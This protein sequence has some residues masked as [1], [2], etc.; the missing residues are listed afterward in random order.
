[1]KQ[2]RLSVIKFA[3][4]AGVLVA[5][6]LLP[7]CASA[8]S[9]DDDVKALTE[10]AEK[11]LAHKDLQTTINLA[12]QSLKL[13]PTP[14]AYMLR[15][16]ASMELF[17]F[18]DA[19]KDA[20][21][22]IEL[23]PKLQPAFIVR[24]LARKSLGDT[25]GSLADAK[26][27]AELDPTNIFWL[28]VTAM[29]ECEG[30]DYKDAL[31]HY[32]QAIALLPGKTKPGVGNGGAG[33]GGAGATG[34]SSG[35]APAAI[36]FG[37]DPRKVNLDTSLFAGRAEANAMLGN[38]KDSLSDYDQ[39]IALNPSSPRYFVNRGT[40]KDELGDHKGAISDYDEAIKLKP[41]D[42]VA[43]KLRSDSKNDLGDKA[44]AVA[45]LEKS[46]SLMK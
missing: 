32:S 18:A 41:D 7:I 33:G 16:K 37:A 17:K 11:A 46:S 42:P 1:M 24:A 15:A 35:G 43:Y 14:V 3:K 44:G 39:A 23:E 26:K 22:A 40:V 9:T 2:M 29:M 6:F 34:G 20:S 12:N 4:C 5:V 45:D 28:S 27:A 38:F 21:S 19:N 31:Q 10:Q 8:A 30:K 13:H 25:A 36:D